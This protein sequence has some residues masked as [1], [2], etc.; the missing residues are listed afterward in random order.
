MAQ[1]AYEL[2]WKGNCLVVTGSGFWDSEL[3]TRYEGELKEKLQMAPPSGFGFLVDLSETPV[4]DQKIVERHAATTSWLEEA[5]CRASA[6]IID[7]ALLRMQVKRAAAGR[8]PLEHFAT[9][10]E[11]FAWLRTQV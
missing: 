3:M 10:D 2:I 11:A 8:I 4:Q 5:G 1:G 6:M 7:S 9:H